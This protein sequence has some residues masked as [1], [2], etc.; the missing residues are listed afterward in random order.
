MSPKPEPSPPRD[1]LATTAERRRTGVVVHDDRG[2]GRLEWVDVA[3]DVERTTLSVEDSHPV[4]R[5]EHGYD[6]YQTTA[7][8]PRR[9]PGGSTGQ[10]TRSDL[11]KLSEWIKQMRRLEEWKRAEGAED[12]EGMTE[13]A[14]VSPAKSGEGPRGDG[15]A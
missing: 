4:S 10:T 3:P 6:P 8:S 7:R 15:Q 5:P 1:P 2:N 11:R 12:A 13:A 9:R 14:P